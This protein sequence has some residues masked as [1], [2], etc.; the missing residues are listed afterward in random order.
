MEF[1]KA[2]RHTKPSIARPLATLRVSTLVVHFKQLLLVLYTD[3]AV[4]GRS[5]SAQRRSCLG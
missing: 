5:D 4:E 3:F 1:S 2:R